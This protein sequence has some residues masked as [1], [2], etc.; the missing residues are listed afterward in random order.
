MEFL[1]VE[2]KGLVEPG[3]KTNRNTKHWHLY[4]AFVIDKL[5][6]YI[7]GNIYFMWVGV[8]PACMSVHHIHAVP[9]EARTG[10]LIL[11]E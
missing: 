7:I 5:L 11:S 8:L 10:H 1:G 4:R 9:V 6:K 2:G 3:M